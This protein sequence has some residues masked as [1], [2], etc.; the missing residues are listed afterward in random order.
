[1]ARYRWR[2]KG[3]CQNID[4]DSSMPSNCRAL[5]LESL[6]NT[7]PHTPHQDPPVQSPPARQSKCNAPHLSGPNIHAQ[8]SGRHPKNQ[9]SRYG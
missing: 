3:R 4:E 7:H 8:A 2:K 1:M 6:S 9:N 5:K